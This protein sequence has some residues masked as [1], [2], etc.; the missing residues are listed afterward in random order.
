MEFVPGHGGC[1]ISN[2][3]GDHRGRVEIDSGRVGRLLSC[4]EAD[5]FGEFA[6][7]AYES[8]AGLTSPP[9]PASDFSLTALSFRVLHALRELLQVL[10]RLV[11]PIFYLLH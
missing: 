6:R 10:L 4:H 2:S 7:T 3:R 11:Q 1:E 9:Q 5:I 8:F